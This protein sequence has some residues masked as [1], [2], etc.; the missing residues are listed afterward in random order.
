[1]PQLRCNSACCERS[2][3]SKSL[4]ARIDGERAAT[5]HRRPDR[6]RSQDERKARPRQRKQIPC[7]AIRLSRESRTPPVILSI[8]SRSM[9]SIPSRCG[10]CTAVPPTRS[11]AIRGCGLS[12]TL[13]SF[14][15]P[16]AD[17]SE[18]TP[19]SRRSSVRRR[20]RWIR[21]PDPRKRL[22]PRSGNRMPGNA[23]G[24]RRGAD[25]L[26][27]SPALVSAGRIGRRDF[28]GAHSG[29]LF[30]PRRFSRCSLLVLGFWF[31]EHRR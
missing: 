31:H 9:R 18:A 22:L 14:I 23:T 1:M 7:R 19:Q 27:S 15:F 8:I 30:S 3:R 12:S 29:N 5:F 4:S 6:P 28:D 2:S 10:R 21:F 16:Q 25:R 26:Q 20:E 11:L 24:R 17:E 13:V